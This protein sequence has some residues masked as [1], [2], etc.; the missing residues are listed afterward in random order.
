[1]RIL[2]IVFVVLLAGGFFMPAGAQTS[3]KLTF[4]CNTYAPSANWGN[5]HVAAIWIQNNANPSVF[6]KTKAKYGH[7][8]DHLTSWLAASG[9]NLVDAVTGA[10]LS[11]YGTLSVEWNGTDVSGTVVPDGDYTIF[12]E[13]GWG[14]DKVAQHATSSFTFTK[15]GTAQQLSPNGNNNY[16]SIN[17]NWQPTATLIS[18]IE[19]KGGI[20][21]YPNPTTGSVQINIQKDLHDV[22]LSLADLSGKIVYREKQ[23]SII[24]GIKILDI[25]QEPAGIYLL[26]IKT[27]DEY[28][29]YKLIVRK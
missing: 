24:T 12:I 5:K 10:T 14:R 27:E 1:M 20:G 6:V 15:S 18:T 25:S 9:K 26:S 11:S 3:G 2:K 17:I 28:F 21:V 16:S 29:R 13:M 8:D 19:E 23:Q 22:E 4:S 7:E